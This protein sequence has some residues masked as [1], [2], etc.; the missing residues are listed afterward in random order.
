MNEGLKPL[1]DEVV[2]VEAVTEDGVKKSWT[3]LG[4]DGLKAVMDSPA[5][6]QNFS[7]IKSDFVALVSDPAAAQD[8]VVYF[9]QKVSG[10][11]AGVQGVIVAGVDLA[12]TGALK[13]GKLISA[14]KALK[15]EQ[16]AAA[17]APAAAP[18][19]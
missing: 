18:S 7:K 11:S 10:K 2:D 15:A 19:A 3:Q 1:V 17:P 6:I 13:V 5:L 8:L 14:I 4:A 16:A 12:A 9:G